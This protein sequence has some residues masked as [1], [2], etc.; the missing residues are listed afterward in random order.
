MYQVENYVK[1]NMHRS[2]RS[3]IAQFRCGIL[4][5]RVETGRYSRL[6]Y[7]QR[8]C[9][10]CNKGE[11]ESEIHFMFQCP[12]YSQERLLLNVDANRLDNNYKAMTDKEKLILL[13]NNKH[14]LKATAGYIKQ[15]LA[16]RT[17]QIYVSSKA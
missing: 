12:L 15:A 11:V 17:C 6:N 13:F 9:Q 5:L 16:K 2:L 14:I 10:V 1:L 4:P 8:I 3:V 7:D